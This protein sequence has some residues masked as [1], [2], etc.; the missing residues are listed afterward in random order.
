MDFRLLNIIGKVYNSMLGTGLMLAGGAWQYGPELWMSE[1]IIFVAVNYRLG[2]FGFLSLGIDEAPGNQGLL[3]QRLAMLWVRDNIASFMGDPDQ[4]T[5]AGES[6]GSFS[7][8]YHM[9][10]PGS[11]VTRG[12]GPGGSTEW[13]LCRGSTT[14]SSARA[15]W[16]PSPPPSTTGRGSR[17]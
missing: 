12:R 9:M 6:A 4:V 16:R 7:V 3:D 14:G 13:W 11:Q 2:P 10:S 17:G 8:F 15:G 1:E 5:I